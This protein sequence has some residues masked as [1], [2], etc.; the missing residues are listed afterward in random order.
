[1]EKS[2]KA[3]PIWLIAI[4]VLI[5]LTLLIERVYVADKGFNLFGEEPPPPPKIHDEKDAQLQALEKEYK[6][7]QSKVRRLERKVKELTPK[8]AATAKAALN[9]AQKIASLKLSE[10]TFRQ[11]NI[12]IWYIES[13]SIDALTIKKEYEKHG[14]FT[15]AFDMNS[16]NDIRVKNGIVYYKGGDNLEAAMKSIEMFK[17]FGLIEYKHAS[18]TTD[19]DLLFHLK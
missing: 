6:Q 10:D 7:L 11:K 18:F 5:L 14:A 9:K 2:I 3:T 1:M 4:A 17:H 12:A 8:K 15:N 19:F 16:A 13:R